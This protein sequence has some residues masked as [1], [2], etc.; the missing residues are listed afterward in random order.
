[1][2]A[3]ESRHLQPGR[4]D[5]VHG[6]HKVL[7]DVANLPCVGS[8]AKQQKSADAA[9]FGGFDQIVHGAGGLTCEVVEFFQRRFGTWCQRVRIYVRVSINNFHKKASFLPPQGR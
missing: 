7:V 6:F 5:F 8:D 2:Y 4:P 9:F 3:A 1:M